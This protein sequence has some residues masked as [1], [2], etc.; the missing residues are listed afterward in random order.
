MQ[1]GMGEMKSGRSGDGSK[2]KTHESE[3]SMR[4]SIFN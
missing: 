4:S 3:L 1:G 2:L